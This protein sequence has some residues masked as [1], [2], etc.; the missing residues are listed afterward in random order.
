MGRDNY[1][2][3][4]RP[5]GADF[6][7]GALPPKRTSEPLREVD[8]RAHS[9]AGAILPDEPT[10][11]VS[12]PGTFE[13]NRALIDPAQQS[14]ADKAR[15]AALPMLTIPVPNPQNEALPKPGSIVNPNQT[16]FHNPSNSSEPQEATP[17]QNGVP[18]PILPKIEIDLE[19]LK[20]ASPEELERLM[21]ELE[22]QEAEVDRLETREHVAEQQE[23]AAAQQ[24]Q[25]AAQQDIDNTLQVRAAD[26]E[27]VANQGALLEALQDKTL[28]TAQS[29]LVEVE[30]D[31]SRVV[32][33]EQVQAQVKKEESELQQE[34]A[35]AGPMGVNEV[36]ALEDHKKVIINIENVLFEVGEEVSPE[37]LQAKLERGEPIYFKENGKVKVLGKTDKVHQEMVG[38]KKTFQ[39]ISGETI[40]ATIDEVVTV[41]HEEYEDLRVSLLRDFNNYMLNRQANANRTQ[42]QNQ[43]QPHRIH[44]ETATNTERTPTE[45]TSLDREIPN[46]TKKPIVKEDALAFGLTPK[47]RLTA[48]AKQDA[49]RQQ[50]VHD[51]HDKYH[52]ADIKADNLKEDYLQDT[53]RDLAIK[54]ELLRK[55]LTTPDGKDRMMAVLHSDPRIKIIK[56]IFSVLKQIQ[57]FSG[58]NQ[59]K[60]EIRQYLT[61]L[62]RY[63]VAMMEATGVHVAPGVDESG[64]PVTIMERG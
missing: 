57:F 9:I 15:K 43:P 6:G 62:L 35:T 12:S 48:K 54:G 59:N 37:N 33:L 49:A 60:P 51:K 14:E 50:E 22:Q 45:S 24:E 52:K 23:Q 25:A 41:S 10:F 21:K 55:M 58:L 44:P 13:A 8:A 1:D 29:A 17:V 36:A 31:P 5:S 61:T 32:L 64:H 39:S 56:P 26:E 18:N 42:V 19:S 11:P 7:D 3:V 20:D 38:Q 34:V 47:Q 30:A 63:A 46:V 4:G 40:E 28:T 53:H 2:V 27:R 16:H